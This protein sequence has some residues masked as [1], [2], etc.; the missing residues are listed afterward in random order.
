MF[1]CQTTVRHERVRED[2]N[3]Y[4]FDLYNFR[5]TDYLFDLFVP[6]NG[7]SPPHVPS[8][9]LG[10]WREREF[11]HTLRDVDVPAD[12]PYAFDIDF[13]DVPAVFVSI[14]GG[15]SVGNYGSIS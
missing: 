7:A 12:E 2:S 15:E 14:C 1:N 4:P 5:D 8:K 6:N 3:G 9:D 11:L 10:H 13:G